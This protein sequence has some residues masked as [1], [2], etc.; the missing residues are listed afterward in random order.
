MPY[1]MSLSKIYLFSFSTSRLRGDLL[2]CKHIHEKIIPDRGLVSRERQ[3]EKKGL[4]TETRLIIP[5]RHNLPSTVL[6]FFA[7][8]VEAKK[9]ITNS[10]GDDCFSLLCDNSRS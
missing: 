8:K 9:K 2:V 1:S 6:P 3:N 7:G 10:K 5:M 4:Q